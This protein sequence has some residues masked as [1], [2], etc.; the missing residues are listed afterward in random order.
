MRCSSADDTYEG[1]IASFAIDDVHFVAWIEE[2][3]SSY[4][5]TDE[6]HIGCST[7]VLGVIEDF[8]IISVR[9]SEKLACHGRFEPIDDFVVLATE[10]CHAVRISR[11]NMRH[12]VNLIVEYKF[13]T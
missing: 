12:Y 7:W 9:M 5:G 10:Y 1:R 11:R 8:E 13:S 4:A 2:I 6:G 3:E